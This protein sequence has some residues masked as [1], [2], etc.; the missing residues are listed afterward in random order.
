MGEPAKAKSWQFWKRTPAAPPPMASYSNNQWNFQVLYPA[1]WKVLSENREAGG[2]T[3]A[4]AI[5][6]SS[7]SKGSVGM[8]VNARDGTVLAKV[9]SLSVVSIGSQGEQ[10]KLAQSPAEFL[11]TI[12]EDD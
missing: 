11:R 3:A 6:D 4:V 7:G 12:Q 9:S 10:R 8:M 2:W 5:G 1:T